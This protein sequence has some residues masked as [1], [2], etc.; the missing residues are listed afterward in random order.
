MTLQ[1]LVRIWLRHHS[2]LLLHHLHLELFRAKK[3]RRTN[4]CNADRALT[5]SIDYTDID[6]GH[7][8]C[9]SSEFFLHDTSNILQ[10]I[11]F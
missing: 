1:K 9:T 2:H 10:S 7:K 4:N 5:D 8:I 3:Y 11:F 6:N